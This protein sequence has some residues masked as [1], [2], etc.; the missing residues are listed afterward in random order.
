[1]TKAPDCSMR[2]LFGR[3]IEL[4]SQ[5]ILNK[6]H[7]QYIKGAIPSDNDVTENELQIALHECVCIM[8]CTEVSK[9]RYV[10]GYTSVPYNPR[11]V[12]NILQ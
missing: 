9:L 11:L 1:M 6:A 3:K 8:R 10:N 5:L 7:K 12:L 2:Q 4:P